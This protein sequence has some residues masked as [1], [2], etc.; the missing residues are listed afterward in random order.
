MSLMFLF[1]VLLTSIFIVL[2]M[3]VGLLTFI[4]WSVFNGFLASFV[5]LSTFVVCL[6]YAVLFTF[7]VHVRCVCCIVEVSHIVFIIL[8]LS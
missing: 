7:V 1:V 6:C 4:L 8:V 5:V 3:F 2:L